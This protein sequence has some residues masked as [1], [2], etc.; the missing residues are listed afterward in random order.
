MNKT[1]DDFII[2]DGILVRYEGSGGDVVIPDGVRVIGS[3]AFANGSFENGYEEDCRVQTINFPPS[4]EDIREKAFYKNTALREITFSEG[5]RHIGISAFSECDSLR[6]LVIPEGVE[7]IETQ[8]FSD[9]K[10]L[11]RINIPSS[12]KIFS[13]SPYNPYAFER[14]YDLEEIAIAV[15]SDDKKHISFLATNLFSIQCL[16]DYY[17]AGK[18]RTNELLNQA[19]FKR[20]NTKANR[21]W[22][23]KRFLRKKDSELTGRF[24]SMI[25]KMS[26]EEIDGYILM[27]AENPEICSLFVEYKNNLYSPDDLAEMALIK[28]EKDLGIRERNLADWKQIFKINNRGE[29][30]GYKE[31]SPIVEIPAFVKNTQFNIGAYAFKGC[32]FLETVTVSEGVEMIDKSAFNG[33]NKLSRITIPATLKKIGASAFK[34]CISLNDVWFSDRITNIGSKAFE[35]CE[36]LVIHAPA[37]S[38]IIKY[39]K[40][41]SICFEE[42]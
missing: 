26:A 18:I 22:I 30:T 35:G 34:N 4:L 40:A 2:E 9:C 8:A 6:E 31:T 12:I 36:N 17:L 39:A 15:D 14:L 3:Q 24:L 38:K 19:F 27:S 7:W 10:R 33:C 1:L 28:Q 37:G 25:K 21:S 32:D 20:L 23:F 5:L 29:I 42:E 16:A 11:K 41:N 13:G